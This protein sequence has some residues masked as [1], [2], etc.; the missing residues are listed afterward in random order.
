MAWQIL[1]QLSKSEIE[2]EKMARKVCKILS[3]S[4]PNRN[5]DITINF[6][7]WI[8]KLNEQYSG[9]ICLIKEVPIQWR[10]HMLG[11]PRVYAR[12]ML[13]PINKFKWKI[14]LVEKTTPKLCINI[15]SRSDFFFVNYLFILFT[16]I[17][18]VVG[19]ISISAVPT[20]LYFITSLLHN[21]HIL[22]LSTVP[23]L[24]GSFFIYGCYW[25][26]NLHVSIL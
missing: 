12:K 21:F 8:N 5:V 23:F 9:M 13:L 25:F 7:L 26:I 24:S 16:Y 18:V 22:Q 19:G 3:S 2:D 11:N 15:V 10:R 1:V 20:I 6:K 14:Q 4:E 17:Y